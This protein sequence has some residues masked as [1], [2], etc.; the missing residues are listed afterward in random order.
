MFTA[1]FNCTERKTGLATATASV[2]LRLNTITLSTMLSVR[3]ICKWR[4][5]EIPC[6]YHAIFGVGT[7]CDTDSGSSVD[8]TTLYTSIAVV[9]LLI[10]VVIAFVIGFQCVRQII[11]H[12][13]EQR[14]LAADDE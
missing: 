10:I 3:K 13:K 7:C 5:R 6:F 8:T 4:Y 11:H 1:Y 2:F 9:M 14:E 12:R